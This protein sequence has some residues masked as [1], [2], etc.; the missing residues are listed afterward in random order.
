M[1]SIRTLHCATKP[2]AL[3]FKADTTISRGLKRQSHWEFNREVEGLGFHFVRFPVLHPLDPVSESVM[4]SHLR[5][6]CVIQTVVI[7]AVR[8]DRPAL[9]A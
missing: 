6:C 2:C 8:I 7:F 5:S 3:S 4:E 1:R 9:A